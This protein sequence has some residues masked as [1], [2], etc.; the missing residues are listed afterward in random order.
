M[1]IV[2]AVTATTD[3]L[4]IA[5][6]CIGGSCR[7]ISSVLDQVYKLAP[8]AANRIAGGSDSRFA[9]AAAATDSANFVKEVVGSVTLYNLKSTKVW[10]SA[11]TKGTSLCGGARPIQSK[12]PTGFGVYREKDFKGFKEVRPHLQLRTLFVRRAD[13][14]LVSCLSCRRCRTVHCLKQA[15][16]SRCLPFCFEGV[17]AW[18]L[19]H[20]FSRKQLLPIPRGQ[21]Y[22]QAFLR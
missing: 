16:P 6:D 3:I 19:N 20:L 22:A 7:S 10:G 14:F 11:A 18:L 2:Q 17:C 4:K 21:L 12:A 9:K 8:G 13:L 5:T 15:V 1:V